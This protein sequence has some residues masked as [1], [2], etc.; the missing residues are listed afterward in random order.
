MLSNDIAGRI[1]IDHDSVCA[2]IE[3]I[4][5]D[6]AGFC[7]NKYFA[8][9]LGEKA[10]SDI[11]TRE[12][13][14]QRHL[15]EGFQMVVIG[16]FK[17]GKSTLI[18]ALL[19]EKAVPTAVTPETVT[20]N[21]LF[22]SE[23]P[24]IEA[25]LKNNRRCS[26]SRDELTREV[27][28]EV[29]ESLPSKIEYIDIGMD[30]DM[31]RDI[32]V[33]DTP[34]M[35]DLLKAFDDQV[36]DYLVNADAV[37]YVISAR[38]P[39]SFEE[40]AFLSTSVMPQSFSRV[41]LVV[42]MA[43]TLETEDN[44]QKVSQLVKDRA[45][46]ISDRIYVY[47]L[48]ALDEFC[49]KRSLDRPEPDLAKVLEDN[50]AEFENAVREDMILQKD[51]IRTTRGIELA[52]MLISEVISYIRLAKNSL[53]ANVEN[54]EKNEDMF[55][56]QEQELQKKID[57]HRQKICDCVLEMEN[58]TKRWMHDFLERMKEEIKQNGEKA[59]VSD[60]QRYFQFYL[61]DQI[62][63]AILACTQKHQKEI[64]DLLQGSAKE[65]SE[66]VSGSYFGSVNAQIADCITDI[67]WTGVDTAMFASDL[68]L[69]M[70]GLSNSVGNLLIIG[71]AVAG[72]MRQKKIMQK[73]S[74]IIN[75]ALQ[76]FPSV[77]TE[78]MTN[79]HQIYVKIRTGAL[80]KLEELYEDQREVSRKAIEQARQIVSD[81]NIKVQDVFEFLDETLEELSG[82][83][84]RLNSQL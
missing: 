75:P 51:V 60:L 59:D 35:G 52:R 78:I 84:E 17:R 72:A 31:L 43:D 18:N 79:I 23:T 2:L 71:Q 39:L 20:I 12:N 1:T 76:A 21:R 3:E 6:I 33:I 47:I 16:D 68:F 28:E 13:A 38:S 26:L 65:L 9:A 69:S 36:A 62:K 14:V 4:L 24:K 70:S 56:S 46:A 45:Q 34:G 15:H 80:S 57:R 49:R 8:R 82:Y 81:E 22:Y 48:S 54:L 41:F 58:E 27:L 50:F 55:Q 30:H 44:M 29:A 42:N 40:Q 83:E 53:K 19:G 7:K 63:G 25:I 61:M 73:Q 67:S 10:I 32:T 64:S 11:R 77:E 74:D 37:V 66:E 5:G